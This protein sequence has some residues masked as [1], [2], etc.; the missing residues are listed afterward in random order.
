MLIPPISVSRR[1]RQL[2]QADGR[3]DRWALAVSLHS[4]WG[5]GGACG[6]DSINSVTRERIF[7]SRA[8]SVSIEGLLQVRSGASEVTFHRA[9]AYVQESGDR[10]R[11]KIVPVGQNDDGP[12]SNAETGNRRENFGSN[13]GQFDSL[14]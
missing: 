9:F 11:I 2:I 6:A 13:L 12:L 3:S 1:E 8:S 10:S 7:T 14:G 4:S 5:R